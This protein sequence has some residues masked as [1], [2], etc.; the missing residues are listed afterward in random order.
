MMHNYQLY[1]NTIKSLLKLFSLEQLRAKVVYT[2]FLRRHF[3]ELIFSGFLP[4]IQITRFFGRL[5]SS[6]HK[7]GRKQIF[8]II[9]LYADANNCSN[10]IPLIESRRTFICT[11]FDENKLLRVS[12]NF[13]LNLLKRFSEN[14]SRVRL[15]EYPTT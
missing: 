1:V 2:P 5:T 7:L 11:N 15:L 9:E 14:A 3:G 8:D 10:K 6:F 13:I 4:E 12:P